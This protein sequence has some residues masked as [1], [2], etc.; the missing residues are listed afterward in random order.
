MLFRMSLGLPP[1]HFH[2]TTGFNPTDIH[3]IPK[4]PTTITSNRPDYCSGSQEDGFIAHVFPR[5]PCLSTVMTASTLL[6]Y[7]K[8]CIK[9][10]LTPEGTG[11]VSWTDLLLVLSFAVVSITSHHQNQE[12]KKF[13]QLIDLPQ[14]QLN[15]LYDIRC[16]Q[17]VV[18]GKCSQYSLALAEACE[19]IELIP[20][21]PTAYVHKGRALL[22]LRDYSEAIVSMRTSL[23]LSILQSSSTSL[24]A[25]A[26]MIQTARDVI[27]KCNEHLAT[28]NTE[29]S[30]GVSQ[31]YPSTPHLPFSPSVNADDTQWSDVA[32]Q[33]SSVLGNLIV[34]TEKLDG[35]NCCLRNGQVFGR[36]HS[37]EATHE[38]FGLLREWYLQIQSALPSHLSFFGE[39]MFAVH[40]IEYD[41]LMH[42]FYLFGIRDDDA[43]MWLSWSDV[44]HWAA[45]LGIPTVPVVFRGIFSS[46]AEMQHLMSQQAVVKSKVSTSVCPEGFVVRSVRPIVDDEF[47]RCIAKFVRAN[48]I[49][50]TPQ[51]K[52]EWKKAVIPPYTIPSDFFATS[53]SGLNTS[54]L[55]SSPLSSP[56]IEEGPDA[57]SA[58]NVPAFSAS[59]PTR[60]SNSNASSK[61]VSSGSKKPV[62]SPMFIVL[63][64]L[65]G[66]GKSTLAEHLEQ[67]GNGQ[68]VRVSQ[69]VMRSRKA[70]E[71]AIGSLC[72]GEMKQHVIVDRC[73][74]EPA[75]RQAMLQLAF[76]PSNAFAVFFDMDTAGCQ[77]R[78]SGRTDHPTIP[79]GRGNAI[80]E[81]FAKRLVPPTISE[82]FKEV[83]VIREFDQVESLL[84]RWGVQEPL[85]V[86][87]HGLFKFPRT[88]HV[89][90]TGGTAVTRDDLVMDPKEAR[91]FFDGNTIVTIEE[92]IDGANIGLSLT[93]EYTVQIQNRSHFVAADSQLQFSGLSQWVDE[94]SWALCTLLKPEVEILFGE[95]LLA[96]HSIH[97]TRLP[98][99]FIAFDIY[100]KTTGKFLSVEERNQRLAGLEIPIIR[101]I[102]HKIFQSKE[103][104]L[105]LLETDS[106]YYDGK[107][108]GIFLRVDTP[109]ASAGEVSRY[110]ERRGKLVRPDF[111]HTI[112]EHWTS[113][114]L[115]KN[116]VDFELPISRDDVLDHGNG[117]GNEN[118]DITA[119]SS[120]VD[121]NAVT[122]KF[123][124]VV[125]L[126]D[127]NTSWSTLRHI[128]P[129]L[130]PY[131]RGSK[132]V[133]AMQ[134]VFRG[135]TR[136][137]NWLIPGMVL[138]CDLDSILTHTD[139]IVQLGITT[140]V[141][142][143]S[144]QELANF[145]YKKQI[146][147]FLPDAKFRMQPIPDQLVTDDELVVQLVS[148]LME[149][150]S[151]GE[152]IAAHCKGGHGRTGTVCSVLLAKVYNLSASEA[153]WR[154]QCC[155]DTRAEPVFRARTDGDSVCL[156]DIQRQQ[157]VRILSSSQ[158]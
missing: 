139:K 104:L 116:L 93:A 31:K 26:N 101:C 99:Y 24:P 133:D 86:S 103:A 57:I 27:R 88:Q 6:E 124:S 127:A 84:R 150:L 91:H 48:H 105:Q 156:T 110:C 102:A 61:S 148:E 38:S 63:V 117:N 109:P 30:C 15:I 113:K 120:S 18:Q 132:M 70:V 51:W 155:H 90:N 54:I 98:G 7:V 147:G 97:Y 12:P 56:R 151:N 141:C 5:P 89:L 83:I 158:P 60:A 28:D 35:A 43:G 153:L 16:A 71:N 66:S 85:A 47:D 4:C 1:S 149:R 121:V 34:M 46:L 126:N 100:N 67:H 20:D 119:S 95:W 106:A 32:A 36:T 21:R 157:V 74:V 44:E 111:I 134:S 41:T 62:S 69:D 118:G 114:K 50:T 19:A 33:H 154:T 17:S 49:Q 8:V 55:S 131:P 144:K 59:S 87:P 82:G 81:S 108:E 52:I 2:I 53:A 14:E 11:F 107:V 96:A 68:W 22:L 73:N 25:Q 130:P 79:F 72:R 142:L 145:T 140:F 125:A 10:K 94:H 65:P 115:V 138:A 123:E 75:D 9:H 13:A 39:N 3:T 77:Q 42:T 80:V 40:S 64:G 92:K 129:A 128:V 146:C 112:T 137:S 136:R 45:K 76:A 37:H 58:L 23:R 152:R 143:L 122:S 29:S 135:P 78:V